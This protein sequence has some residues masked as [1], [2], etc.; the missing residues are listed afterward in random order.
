MVTEDAGDAEEVDLHQ[1]F[2]VEAAPT[3]VLDRAQTYLEAAGSVSPALR[4]RLERFGDSLAVHH[5]RIRTTVSARATGQGARVEVFRVGRAPFEAT[6]KW[7]YGVGLAGFLIAWALAVYNQRA[8]AA[9]GPLVTITLFLLGLVALA[10]VLYVVDNS[11]ER[12]SRSLVAS[13][14]DAVRGDPFL[15]LRS[16]IEALERSSS[17]VG[18]LL[19]YF[20]SLLAEFLVFV[21]LFSEGVA[22][23]IDRAVTLGFMRAGFLLPL[24]PA[25]LFGVGWF[26]VSRRMHRGRFEDVERRL[27]PAARGPV[28]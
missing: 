23:G 26:M 11:L 28:A 8:E 20:A 25:L 3:A 19:F 27:R 5:G 2:T 21:L 16:Q 24:V 22:E 12:R 1:R 17:L 6:R 7:L 10:V 18:A 4:G 14:E 9:L 13:V 15:V